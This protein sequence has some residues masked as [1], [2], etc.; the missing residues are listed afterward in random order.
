MIA[1]GTASAAPS[2]HNIN[3]KGAGQ[4][5]GRG[6]TVARIGGGG[7]LRGT[8]AGDFTVTGAS[9]TI[10]NISGKVTFTTHQGTLTV[11]V[12]G[13]L[14]TI[15]GTFRTAGPVTASTGKLASATGSLTF[16][17]TENLGTGSFVEDVSGTVC[18]DL[19]P[20]R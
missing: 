5:P 4:D 2:C 3:G 12:S 6:Q 15:T 16:D 13:T 1:P 10:L 8:T 19:A 9:G 14:D 20:S 18:V 7:L 17:G 11:S